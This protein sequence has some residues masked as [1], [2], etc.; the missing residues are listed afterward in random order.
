MEQSNAELASPVFFHV[1]KDEQLRLYVDYWKFDKM[2]FKHSYP[3][4]RVDEC[5]VAAEEA[6]LFYIFDAFNG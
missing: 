3:L 6:G 5:F 2:T 1:K 4:P